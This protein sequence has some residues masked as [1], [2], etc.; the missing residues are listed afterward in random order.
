MSTF[1]LHVR[2]EIHM[3]PRAVY[4]FIPLILSVALAGPA[5]AASTVLGGGLA[6]ACSASALDGRDDDASLDTCNLALESEILISRDRAAT[7]VNR[8]V[9]LLRRKAWTQAGRDFDAAIALQ[10]AMGEAFVNRGAALLGQRRWRE[11]KAEIDRGLALGA[12]EPEKAYF[13]RAIAW[14]ALDNMEAAWR[15]YSQAA[16]LKPDWDA[17]RK[18]LARFTVTPK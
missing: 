6:T 11:G 5:A 16:A 14:E 3:T 10:P 7:F 17:P 15:D 8:G 18:E 9:I 13:N 2:E 4:A 12:D 1:K